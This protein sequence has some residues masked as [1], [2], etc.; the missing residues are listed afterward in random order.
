MPQIAGFWV[1][2]KQ[3]ERFKEVIDSIEKLGFYKINSFSDIKEGMYIC[4]IHPREL[5]G[6]VLSDKEDIKESKLRIQ[7]I[8]AI[9]TE[10]DEQGGL[11]FDESLENTIHLYFLT[12]PFSKDYE[13][14]INNSL[15]L[16][17]ISS[18]GMGY[19][20]KREIEGS[21]VYRVDIEKLKDSIIKSFKTLGS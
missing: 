18:S 7:K 15:E 12:E 5:T 2:E 6:I 20:E 8:K 19:F 3:V 17:E 10:F 13:F 11:I 9:G 16:E 14:K 21:L 1:E 4:K